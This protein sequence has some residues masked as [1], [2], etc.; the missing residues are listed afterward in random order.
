MPI[1]I[2]NNP[3][4]KGGFQDHPE[5]MSGGRWSKDT[6]ISYWLNFFI[7]LDVAKFRQWEKDVE[8]QDRSVAQ[9]IAYARVFAARAAL[10]ESEFV[11]NRTEGY[12]MQ[13]IEQTTVPE[14]LDNLSEEE[15]RAKIREIDK[16]LKGTARGK[17]KTTDAIDVSKGK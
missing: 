6:S 13:Q 12:P 9:S 15:L 5:L 17:D 2:A 8:E 1:G 3:T 10:K 4:G 11:T 7:R 16:K 14:D